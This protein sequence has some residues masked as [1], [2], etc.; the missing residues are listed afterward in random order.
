MTSTSDTPQKLKTLGIAVI[1]PTY[2][3]GKT[4]ETVINGVQQYCQDIFVVNDGCTDNTTDILEKHPELHVINHAVNRGKGTG[5]RNGL[6]AAREAGFRYAITI[7]S[8]GQ[9][10]PD[11]IPT[12]IS[13]IEKTPGNILV[14]ARN[15]TADNMPGKNTFA[16]KFSNF[17]FKLETGINLP[18][19]Q[20]GFRLYPLDKIGDMR[21]LTAKYEFELEILVCAAWSGVPI[22]NIPIR[23]YYPPQNERIS[24]FRPLR[25]FTRISIVNTILVLIAAVW[26]W[27]RNFFRKFSWSNIKKYTHQIIHSNIGS[28]ELTLSVMLGI[29]MGIIPIWG[30]QIVCT[31]FIAHFLKLNKVIAVLF[32]NISIPPMIPFILFGSYATG[33][34]I[35]GE[36]LTFHYDTLN[37][38]NITQ[39]LTQY[40]VGSIIFA[41]LCS[42]LA[43]GITYCI[44]R[45]VRKSQQ[46]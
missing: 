21:L 18:D 28:R 41:I 43:G 6:L 26:I 1:I 8:D 14:G 12:F 40:L 44:I 30:Y 22:R 23:V 3:N 11:D 34:W 37:F 24:H 2:N 10:Y 25:D 27:P 19:T 29:F 9:H 5:L 17:W 45:L 32:S 13:E 31:I 36:E 4:L 15:L 39:V 38:R 35:L 16:N 20:S 7:D 33:C 42:L 46:P